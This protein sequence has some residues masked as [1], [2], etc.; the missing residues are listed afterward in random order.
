MNKNLR[1][2]IQ[3]PFG[4]AFRLISP[5]F[6]KIQNLFIES[7]VGF[8]LDGSINQ[9]HYIEDTGITEA[10]DTDTLGLILSQAQGALGSLGAQAFENWDFAA[11]T[12]WT[13]GNNWAITG[14]Q[15]VGSEPAVTESTSQTPTISDLSFY[16]LDIGYNL[17]SGRAQGTLGGTG[18][19]EFD[20]SRSTV[21][22]HPILFIGS[23][24]S[25]NS[26][27]FRGNDSTPPN[28]QIDFISFRKIPGWHFQQPT[29]GSRP[30]REK[31]SE[32]N[33]FYRL[34]GTDD[35][36]EAPAAHFEPPF[37]LAGVFSIDGTDSAQTLISGTDA[38]S[39]SA[40]IY[41]NH[42]NGVI[43]VFN[44]STPTLEISTGQHPVGPLVV[45][46]VIDGSNSELHV[47]DTVETGSLGARSVDLDTFRLGRRQVDASQYHN[48]RVYQPFG[49]NRRLSDSEIDNLK[50]EL[51]RLS[52]A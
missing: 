12:G 11:A 26:W 34:D 24:V 52:P 41:Y 31:D 15:L 4:S 7:D 16:A 23:G 5:T 35:F 28:I 22:S 38:G 45:I 50:S 42:A 30:T 44:G 6:F 37:V 3:S 29:L 18:N 33:W 10:G 14:G 43:G 19:I 49:I 13:V 8:S 51:K 20:T 1:R 46:A 48:G 40:Q 36:M 39:N 9:N 2:V 25:G 21:L 27:L 17:D 47:G 32:G